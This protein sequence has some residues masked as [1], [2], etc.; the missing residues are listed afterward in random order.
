M[1]LTKA[2][3]DE[4]KA[5]EF[6]PGT[7]AQAACFL[8]SPI[9]SSNVATYSVLQLFDTTDADSLH[10]AAPGTHSADRLFDATDELNFRS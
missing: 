6:A 9:S 4:L 7:A 8:K 1:T 5:D 10:C 3:A 2:A